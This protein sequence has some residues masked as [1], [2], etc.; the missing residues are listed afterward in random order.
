MVRRH[1]RS[2]DLLS[3]FDNYWPDV[4]GIFILLGLLLAGALVGNLVTTLLGKVYGETFVM[5]YGILV[6]YPI[7]FIP[8]MLYA[9]A[10]SRNKFFDAG[11]VPLDEGR[12]SPIGAGWMALMVIISTIAASL[13]FEPV[14]MLLPEMPDW[15]RNLM[16]MLTQGPLWAIVLST[17]IFAP[18]FEEWLCRGMVLR[19]MLKKVKPVWAIV[20]SAAFFAIIHMNPWQALPAF[21]LGCLFGYVYYKTGSLKLTMLMHCANNAFSVVLSR[22]PGCKDCDYV[23]EIIGDKITYGILYAACLALLCLFIARI[24]KTEFTK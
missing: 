5:S 2:F 13:V 24:Y 4:S 7:Q 6:S 23:Y 21:I 17:C 8:A 14:C 3:T 11:S 9:S 22:V 12:F 19:G 10:K 16:E 20:I 1:K 18:F 15:I